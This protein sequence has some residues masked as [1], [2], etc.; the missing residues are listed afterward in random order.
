[1]VENPLGRLA[2]LL[3]GV[4]LTQGRIAHQVLG[5]ML[6]FD[7]DEVAIAGATVVIAATSRQRN[8]IAQAALRT[9][10]PALAIRGLIQRDQERLEALQQL[11]ETRQ[12]DLVRLARIQILQQERRLRRTAAPP[13]LLAARG[14]HREAALERAAAR[15]DV[16]APAAKEPPPP[17]PSPKRR[18][19]KSAA[20]PGTRRKTP[21]TP[22]ARRPSKPSRRRR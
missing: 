8:A 20:K 13:A 15:P 17:S 10:L 19:K 22:A 6:L 1:L 2:R 11:L 18:A 14:S 5:Q 4:V 16:P 3:G 9:A 21:S 7:T 12:D